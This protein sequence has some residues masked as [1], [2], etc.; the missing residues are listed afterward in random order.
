MEDVQYSRLLDA[1]WDLAA[2]REV[3][4]LLLETAF[5]HSVS[6]QVAHLGVNLHSARWH[7]GVHRLAGVHTVVLR[8]ATPEASSGRSCCHC[9]ATARSAQAVSSPL[10][11]AA[12]KG[13]FQQAEQAEVLLQ[14]GAQVIQECGGE[15]SA[16]WLDDGSEHP[17]RIALSM[18]S[19]A[20][21][22]ARHRLQELAAQRGLQ[23]RLLCC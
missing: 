3:L 5:R 13:L 19:G 12:H 15:G 9:P 6:L 10:T 17:H 23:V 11:V 2:V 16:H 4:P 14:V 18:H 21:G 1:G 22:H 20:V 8:M 7:A